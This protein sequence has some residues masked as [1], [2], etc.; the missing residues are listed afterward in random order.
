MHAFMV[1]VFLELILRRR[2]GEVRH[3]HSPRRSPT[4]GIRI[5]RIFRAAA[6]NHI[7]L[8]LRRRQDH[9]GALIALANVGQSRHAH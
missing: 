7:P 2:G 8:L 1:Q 5:I 4:R 3:R 6:Q 9:T